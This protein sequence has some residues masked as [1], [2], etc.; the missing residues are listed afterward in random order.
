[1]TVRKRHAEL[2]GQKQCHILDC[3]GGSVRRTGLNP[4]SDFLCVYPNL[5]ASHSSGDF[6]DRDNEFVLGESVRRSERVSSNGSLG[7]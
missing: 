4:I 6:S 3:A 2:F 7:Y 1:M 5:A